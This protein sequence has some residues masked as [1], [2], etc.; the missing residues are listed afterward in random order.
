M[1]HPDD[2]GLGL[3]NTG[4]PLPTD[5]QRPH[6]EYTLPEDMV[7]IGFKA[8]GFVD[9]DRTFKMIEVSPRQQDHAAKVANGNGSILSRELM[10]ASLW[11]VGDWPTGRSRERLAVWWEAIGAKGRRLVEGAF[12]QMQSV[13]E[14]DVENF[15][16]SGKPSV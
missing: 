1:T 12:M 11:Y 16:A 9:R 14:T 2:P 7:G 10:Y 4:G 3:P 15:L 6:I 8:D 5:K 13:E